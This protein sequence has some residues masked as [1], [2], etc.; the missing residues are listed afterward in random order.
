MCKWNFEKHY[1]NTFILY[2][3]DRSRKIHALEPEM[4]LR[5]SVSVPRYVEKD[6][7]DSD[8]CIYWSQLFVY[9]DDWYREELYSQQQRIP[10]FL[11]NR[12]LRDSS[13]QGRRLWNHPSSITGYHG[14]VFF[15]SY[16]LSSWYNRWRLKSG[17]FLAI[18]QWCL[19]LSQPQNKF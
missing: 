1:Y 5:K 18:N 12:D 3:T 9:R 4:N 8:Q 10:P 6:K 2:F 16:Y 17:F 19:L 13:T 15:M 11:D 7:Y 14:Y